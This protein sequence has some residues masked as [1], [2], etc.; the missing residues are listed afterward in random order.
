MAEENSPSVIEKNQ[1]ENEEEILQIM[2]EELNDPTNSQEDKKII[3][4]FII[5]KKIGEGTFSNVKLAKNRQ[6]GEQVA[7]KIIEKNK[8]KHKEDKLRFNREI[9]ILKKLRHPNIVQLYSIIEKND[10]IYLIMEY[11]KGQELFD[12]IVTKKKLSEKEACIFFQQLI[13]GIEYLHKIKYVHRDIKPENLL[14]NENSK[15]LTIIDFGLSNIYSNSK[16]EILLSSACGSPSYAAPEMLNGEKYKGPPV[17]IWSC[18]I[19]LYAMLCGYLPFDDENN[20]NDKLY[21]KICKGK[22]II[23]NH[24]SEKARDLLN[25]I[26][27][28]DPKKR[29]NIFQIKSH[30]WFSIYNNKGKLMISDGLI[31]SKY[32]IPIDEEIIN[33]MSKEYDINEEKIRISILSNKHDDISTIY[34]LLLN[35][36]IKKKK[37]SEADIK[38]DLFKKYCEN[39]N[40]LMKNYNNDINKMLKERK[41]GYINNL[42]N[43]KRQDN[44]E[45]I[46]SERKRI[47]KK[48][49]RLF[50]PDEKVKMKNLNRK[51][52]KTELKI[53]KNLED[54]FNINKANDKE[55]NHNTKEKI[56]NNINEIIEENKNIIKQIDIND[57]LILTKAT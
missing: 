13:S 46:I 29:L 10:K 44:K 18:G 34:Y 36:K 54:I 5:T 22:F 48:L 41:N 35:K 11:I 21:D 12:Y 43:S 14:I 33:S 3:C 25:K 40:N 51:L 49:K 53:N 26:L 37:K 8:F 16:K 32:V 20:D 45:D 38:S 6:T 23:P 57:Y 7:I 4:D 30:P 28:T 2:S 27:V 17:D 15:Q 1:K 52:N 39:K 47:R 55:S 31:L 19:V 9:E 24:V 56:K 42:E 50:S